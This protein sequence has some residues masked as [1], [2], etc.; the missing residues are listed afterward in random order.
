MARILI[1]EDDVFLR[2][3]LGEWLRLE[4][5]DVMEAASADEAAAI[6]AS[7]AVVDLVITDVQMPGSM[8]GLE[9]ARRIRADRPAIAVIVVSGWAASADIQDLGFSAFFRK[10]YDFEQLSAQI[11][12]LALDQ[13]AQAETRRQVGDE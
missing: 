2:Y 10:P 12:T 9:L 8:D 7:P 6:L 1:V 13:N 11:A 4:D 3:A 5:Y